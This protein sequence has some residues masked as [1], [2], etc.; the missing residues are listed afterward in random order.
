MTPPISFQGFI[1]THI[2]GPLTLF[3]ILDIFPAVILDDWQYLQ[4]R[5]HFAPHFWNSESMHKS[6]D[7]CGRIFEVLT[8]FTSSEIFATAFSDQGPSTCYSQVRIYLH[9]Y[10]RATHII[11]KSGYFFQLKFWRTDSTYKSGYIL[12]RIFE[13]VKVCTSLEIFAAAFLQYWQYLQ[14]R[15]YLQRHFQTRDLQPVIYKSGFIYTHIFRPLTLFT[16]PDIFPAAFLKHWK[17]IQ[18]RSYLQLHSPHFQ[19]IDF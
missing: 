3:T 12:V 1:Y 6:G 2:F 10:L 4:I 17:Y 11:Y 5:L 8:L 18:V 16:S 13:T 15:R 19:I 14:V 7:V 9:L